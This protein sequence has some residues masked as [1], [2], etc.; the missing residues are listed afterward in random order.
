[1]RRGTLDLV[2]DSTRVRPMIAVRC[3]THRTV[4]AIENCP[5]C[6]ARLEE[7]MEKLNRLDAAGAVPRGAFTK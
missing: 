1:M 6:V 4:A 3:A 7:A 2:M 5:R